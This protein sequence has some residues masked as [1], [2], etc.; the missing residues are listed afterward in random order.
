MTERSFMKVF[1]LLERLSGTAVPLLPNGAD[2]DRSK[3]SRCAL[4]PQ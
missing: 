1:F 3:I 4:A 2:E